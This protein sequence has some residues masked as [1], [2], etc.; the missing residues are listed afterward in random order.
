MAGAETKKGRRCRWVILVLVVVGGLIL[1]GCRQNTEGGGNGASRDEI[2]T[3]DQ[4]HDNSGSTVTPE[5]Q[6]TVKLYRLARLELPREAVEQI[7]GVSGEAA[8]DGGIVYR[9]PDSGYGVKVLYDESGVARSKELVPANGA[10]LLISQN[11]VTITDKHL[12]R[13]A[14]GMPYYEVSEIMGSNGIEISQGPATDGSNKKIYGL[15]W[16]NPD[17][18]VA[19]VYLNGPQ[20]EVI[21]AGFK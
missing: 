19:V 16:F 12:Y 18:S 17:Q 21:S 3:S 5:A 11:P 20:G 7:L 4:T 6:K 15:A 9:D 1:P 10:A 14:A 8:S 2:V 13:L